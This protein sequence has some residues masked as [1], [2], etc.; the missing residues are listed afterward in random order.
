M[1]FVVFRCELR[2]SSRAPFHGCPYFVA[3]LF[4]EGASTGRRFIIHFATI[5]RFLCADEQIR[6]ELFE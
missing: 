3:L 5:C 4:P 1:L 6:I 2:H